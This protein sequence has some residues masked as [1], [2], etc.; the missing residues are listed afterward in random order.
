MKEKDK[1]AIYMD[2]L[3]KDYGPKR[4]LENI[5]LAVGPGEFVTVVGPSGCGK[6]TLLKLILGSEDSTAGK[7][8]VV[9]QEVCLPCAERGIVDQKYSMFPNR[10]VLGNIMLGEKLSLSPWRSRKNK[11]EIKDRAMEYLSNVGLAEHAFKY[12]HELSGGQRQRV[13][14]A[15]ALN[16]HPTILLMDEPFSALDAA[17]RKAMQVLILQLW[18]KMGMTIFFVTHDLPEAIYLGTR[19]IALSP[20]YSDDRDANVRSKNGKH[21]ARIVCDYPLMRTAGSTAVTA[22]PAFQ[23]LEGRIMDEAFNPKY[24]QEIEKFNLKHPDSFS[25]PDL[26]EEEVE[27]QMEDA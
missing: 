17:S 25:L 18:E 15:Q 13:A 8:F 7:I 26:P 10:T 20:F 5:N 22:D 3:Y 23:K 19:I 16:A 14:I 24:L 12:P 1:F 21:G 6:S 4:I 2:G 11:K 27:A 9:G